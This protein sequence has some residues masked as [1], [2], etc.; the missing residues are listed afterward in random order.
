MT[1]NKLEISTTTNNSLHKEVDIYRDTLLRYCGK[2]SYFWILI[3]V[4]KQ[5]I[6][7]ILG[8]TNEVGE[9]FRPIIPKMFVNLSYAV[10]ISYVLAECIHK[11]YDTYKV[12]V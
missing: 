11:S 5:S 8:Y 7:L 4:F 1:T 12:I 6:F 3:C 2:Q 9:S 10:A